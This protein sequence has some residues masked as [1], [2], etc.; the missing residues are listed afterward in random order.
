MCRVEFAKAHFGVFARQGVIATHANE[1]FATR[2]T[3]ISPH[4]VRR[5]VARPVAIRLSAKSDKKLLFGR[6]CRLN[7]SKKSGESAVF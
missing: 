2:S 6:P 4:L 3:A 7:G 5:G 1:D